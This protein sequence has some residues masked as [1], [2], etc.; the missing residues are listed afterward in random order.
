MLLKT[1][2][3][4]FVLFLSGGSFCQIMTS[5]GA[6]I[7]VAGAT[8]QVNGGLSLTNSSS[9]ANNGIIV[10]SKNS[11]FP[12]A[13]TFVNG[14]ASAV[15][16]NGGYRVEQDWINDAAFNSGASTVELFGNTQQFI[17]STNS[18]VTT[19][20]NL[21]LTGTG[22]GTNRKKTLQ[23]VN[24]FTGIAGNLEI[25][26]RELETQTNSFFVLNPSPAALTTTAVPGSEGF[27]SS[28]SPGVLSRETNST[29]AYLYPTGSSAGTPRYRPVNIIPNNATAAVYTARMNNQDATAAGFDRSVTD[30]SMCTENPLFFHSI[31]RTSGTAPADIRLYYVTASDGSWSGIAHWRT[32]NAQWND[33]AANIPG[34]AGVFETRM[35][36]AWAFANPGHPY[37][38]SNI[39]PE[40][41]VISCPVICENSTGNEFTL[42]GNSTTY[43]W[44]VPGNGTITSGQGTDAIEASWTTG[45]GYVYAIATGANGCNSLPDSCQ[46]SV[47]PQPVAQFSYVDGANGFEFSDNSPGATLWDWSFGDG[48]TSANENPVHQYNGGGIYTVILAVSN[49]GGCSATTTQLVTV[50]EKVVVPNV[51]S[52]NSDGINDFFTVTSGGLKTYSLYIVNR[53]GNEVFKS[54]NPSLHWDGKS[55][56]NECDEGVYFYT[57]KASSAS[58]EYEYQGM[59]TLIK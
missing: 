49:A 14:S 8:L 3:F 44:T 16:G 55:N 28:L 22:S 46:P 56:G 38:L 6:V 20:N 9:L 34:T 58:K 33:I 26:D 7:T 25:N 10:V 30:G 27:V 5:N 21:K 45:T 24:A 42:T 29:S 48:N 37:I 57:L 50:D 43:Q 36:T 12:L 15:S 41:P 47:F 53:W 17:T 19:F 4:S 40:P 39:R 54:D 11:T 18:T 51:F 32:A 59:V 31:E 52:P 23:L 1:L 2:L 35:R 13:G